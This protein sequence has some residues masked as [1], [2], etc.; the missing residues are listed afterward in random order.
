MF[1]VFILSHIVTFG[2]WFVSSL[3]FMLL[4]VVIFFAGFIFML[5]NYGCTD[6]QIGRLPIICRNISADTV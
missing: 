6:K 3:Q 4:E 2:Y 5:P 1:A